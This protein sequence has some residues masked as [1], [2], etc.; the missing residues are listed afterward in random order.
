MVRIKEVTHDLT[1]PELVFD[2][3]L[4]SKTIVGKS[5]GNGPVVKIKGWA[6]VSS[7]S[8]LS[9]TVTVISFV[10]LGLKPSNGKECVVLYS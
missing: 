8:Y 1:A 9:R 5:L 7:F 3:S 4:F 10:R 6:A 2:L